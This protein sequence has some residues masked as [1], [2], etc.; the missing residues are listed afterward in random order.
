MRTHIPTEEGGGCGKRKAGGRVPASGLDG[1]ELPG[2]ERDKEQGRS[3]AEGRDG[4]MGEASGENRGRLAAGKEAGDG[5]RRRK[6]R[7][8]TAREG[9]EGR[10]KKA[11]RNK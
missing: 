9:T 8:R 4:R 10:R 5:K 2:R 11:E 3:A 6:R 7:R 1:G